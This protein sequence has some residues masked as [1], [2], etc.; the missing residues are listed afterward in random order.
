MSDK[1]GKYDIIEELGKG[2]MGVVYKGYD[3]D[4]DREVAIKVIS[5]QAFHISENRQRFYREARAAGKLLHE[6]I[7]IIYDVSE[8][9]GR[10]FIVMEYLEGTDLRALMTHESRLTL[11]QKIDYAI[12]ICKGLQFAHSKD[13]IHRDIKPEN[14]KVLHNGKVKIMDFGIAKPLASTLTQTGMMI[15]TPYYMSPEQV[16]G[17]KVDKRSD[18]FSFGVLFY[19]LLT[20]NKPFTG[21]HI[22]VIMYCIAHEDP[23]PVQI[24]EKEFKDDIQKI[25][26]KCLAKDCQDRYDDF[27]SVI[28][29]LQRIYQK[30]KASDMPLES[31]P[32]HT[33][34]LVRERSGLLPNL[35]KALTIRNVL[36]LII[37]I[38]LTG[39]LFYF[40]QINLGSKLDIRQQALAAKESLIE[41]KP[42]AQQA[43][44]EIWA[45][46]IFQA[47]KNQEEIGEQALKEKN[48]DLAYRSFLMAK[49]SLKN[50]IDIAKKNASQTAG[51]LNKLRDNADNIKSQML[52]QKQAA[53]LVKARTFFPDIFNQGL[54]LEQ[55]GNDAYE[56]SNEQG[57][58]EAIQHYSNA[59]QIFKKATKQAQDRGKLLRQ[60]QNIQSIVKNTRAKIPGTQSEKEADPNFQKAQNKEKLAEQQF[61]VGAYRKALTTY[62]EVDNL[63]R[64]AIESITNSLR[65]KADQEK[66]AMMA[67]KNEIS[68]ETPKDQN[69]QQASKME[70]EGNAAYQD[71]DFSTARDKYQQASFLFTRVALKAKDRKA[72]ELE[73]QKAIEQALE[74]TIRKYKQSLEEGNI[75]NLRALFVDFTPVEE[76]KWLDLF[77][78]AKN[79]TI[80]IGIVDKSIQDNKAYLDLLVR[81]FFKDNKNR[82]QQLN[83][84]YSWTLAQ[85][86][87]KWL[88]SN[89]KAR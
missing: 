77:K 54:N 74:N 66:A 51:R 79:R 24:D 32:E 46:E 85:V 75:D 59:L 81:I 64:D 43:G 82:K 78:F 56:L 49:D 26:D 83:Y 71:G 5:E 69:Y 2:G 35:G 50:A 68:D 11:Q 21:E 37:G 58:T 87:G 57:F 70:L 76:K 52:K 41:I 88:I 67:A 9:N 10:P 84:A 86:N 12:Q 72:K 1:L 44:V 13:V 34:T 29:D 45:N 63:Y 30:I 42:V 38:A 18:I 16:R 23:P 89:F 73:M 61:K 20:G 15:G 39:V 33:I 31:L 25:I 4:I 65:N 47:A 53:E 60:V 40:V 8:E 3:P 14:I 7:T 17:E 48:Y 55:K 80:D 6:N 27:D 62:Q 36:V 19:E 22:N 28:K